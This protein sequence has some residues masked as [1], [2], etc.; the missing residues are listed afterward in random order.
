M[1]KQDPALAL[2]CAWSQLPTDLLIGIF[3]ALDVLDLYST[4]SV[5]QD[6]RAAYLEARRLAPSSSKNQSPCL[7]HYSDDRDPATDT[8]HRL[9]T[10]TLYH[11]VLPQPPR[12]RRCFLAGSSHGW[13]AITDKRSHLH[14]LN[15]ITRARVNL[16]PPLT[17]KNV[18]GHYTAERILD[19]YNLVY[20]VLDT[21]GCGERLRSNDLSLENGRLF[22]YQRVVISADPSDG[23]C[24]VMIVHM[25][26]PNSLS[27]ARVGDTHWTW[28]DVHQSCSDY[29][30]VFYND[31]DKLFYASR[32]SGGEVHTVDING[33]SPVVKVIV[34]KMTYSSSHYD[35]HYIVVAPWG[36]IL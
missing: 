3:T 1:E 25:A 34:G 6:W 28:I 32:Y 7:L 36:A 4:G 16:P 31:S 33:T 13:L 35:I 10:N 19:G 17:I 24:V 27:F 14:L 26:F 5:C 22:F 29:S 15:P 20:L 8:L 18:R 2:D 23:N 12:F 30:N 11:I 21:R 9:S